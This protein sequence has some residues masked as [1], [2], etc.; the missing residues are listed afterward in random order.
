[1]IVID[2]KE[3]IAELIRSLP[4]NREVSRFVF[5]GDLHKGHYGVLSEIR[6]KS[7]IV[8]A[9]YVEHVHCFDTIYAQKYHE[10]GQYDHVINSAEGSPDIDYLVINRSYPGDHNSCIYKKSEHKVSR[11]VKE[12]KR[13]NLSM[14]MA[15]EACYLLA[16]NQLD[17]YTNSIC[18]PKIILPVMLYKKILCP[19]DSSSPTPIWKL[20]KDGNGDVIS[21]SKMD[22]TLSRAKHM[23]ARDLKAGSTK[24]SEFETLLF[25]YYIDQPMFSILDINSLERLPEI[26]D[27]C[28]LLFMSTKNTEF[29]F[30]RNGKVVE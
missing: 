1:M 27:N 10:F 13:L 30:I 26:S 11:V 22:P 8:I 9:D 24:A 21:R 14:H 28:M 16:V 5:S 2:T 3:E 20:I 18:G 12:C 15:R 17:A 19:Y 6:K 7:D 29:I 23:A 25:D 4:E